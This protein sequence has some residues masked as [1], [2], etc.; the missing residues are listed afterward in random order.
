MIKS[1]VFANIIGIAIINIMLATWGNYY[2]DFGSEEY[3]VWA[4]DTMVCTQN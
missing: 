1:G 2:F 4:N 3:K